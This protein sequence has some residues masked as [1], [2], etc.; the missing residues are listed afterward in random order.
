MVLI[1]AGAL[2]I[3]LAFVVAINLGSPAQGPVPSGTALVT[4]STAIPSNLANGTSL[5][6]ASAPVEIQI[7]SDFQ[8]PICG[9]LAREYLPRLIADFVASG[10]V[11]I[12][13]R[14][15]AFLGRDDPDESLDAATT[16][17]CAIPQ[18]KYWQVHDLLFWNQSGENR[19]A[20]SRD[21]L[22]AI[23]SAAGLD[24]ATWQ[25]CFDGTAVRASVQQATSAALAAGINATPTIIINGQKIVGL[26][27]TYDDLA[28]YVRQLLVSQS[29]GASPSQ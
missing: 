23:A 29:R 26:P 9:R 12:E 5:G 8:C 24:V 10:Q 25:S 7:Y 2:V 28:A 6:S 14:V 18:D 27:R 22:K 3:G 19:G 21:R 16:A 1:T 20:F 4:P 11:R 15:V 17:E 13:D